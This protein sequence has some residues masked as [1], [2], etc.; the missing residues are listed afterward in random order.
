MVIVS[1]DF[2]KQPSVSV[3]VTSYNRMNTVGEAL[4][5]ILAQVCT[6]DFEIIVGDDCSLDSTQEVLLDYQRRYPK[7][8][9]LILQERNVGCGAN[10][11]TSIKACRG[12][13]ICCCDDDDYWHN[14]HKLQ[15][16]V[17][18]MN[19]HPDCSM[20]ATNHL[21][22]NRTTGKTREIK[23]Y[24]DSS[25]PMQQAIFHGRSSFAMQTMMFRKSLIDEHLN[26]DDYIRYQF[27][28]QDWNTWVILS[29]Y[30]DI[31]LMDIS[32]A[33]LCIESPSLSRSQTEGY[34]AF[35]K[36]FDKE[37]EHYKYCCSLFPDT[38]I[39]NQAEWDEYVN[40]LLL[41]MAFRRCDFERAKEYGA[42]YSNKKG[43][44]YICSQH[45]ILFYLFCW[46]KMIRDFVQYS[47]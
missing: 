25:M 1:Q 15:L 32:T 31:H 38:L 22:H 33:T 16:Q 29:A 42:K 18:Y 24:I 27:R 26:L 46:S 41:S 4:D 40:Q 20:L 7:Q 13:F 17:E 36:R 23:A 6:F 11:A 44:K 37:L 43:L 45:R 39:F 34:A 9:K 14:P 8:I 5:S 21:E 2:V 12:E 35:I 19:S 10:W 3:V 28:L 47:R 30:A